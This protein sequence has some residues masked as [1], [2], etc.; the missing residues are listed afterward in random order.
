MISAKATARIMA[1]PFDEGAH[2]KQGAVVVQLDSKELEAL[3]QAAQ[4]EHD[5][6]A[7]ELD[8]QNAHLAGQKAQMQ[9]SQAELADAER[10]LAGRRSCWRARMCRSRWWIRRRRKWMS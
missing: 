10:D 3:L 9:S 4:A 7:A 5:A 2:V 1:M 6:Q 8:V